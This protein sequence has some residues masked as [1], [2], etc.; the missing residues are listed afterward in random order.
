MVKGLKIFFHI[1]KCRI[2]EHARCQRVCSLYM[3]TSFLFFYI[4]L[5]NYVCLPNKLRCPRLEMS[6][7]ECENS[8]TLE[9]DVTISKPY[10]CLEGNFNTKW[11]CAERKEAK[12]T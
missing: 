1:D 12:G 3:G 11:K 4:T 5:L 2:Y 8:N 7:D 9:S 10:F 6:T